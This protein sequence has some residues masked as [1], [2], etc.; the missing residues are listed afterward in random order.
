MNRRDL[1]FFILVFFLLSALMA[2]VSDP[3]GK[4]VLP[5]KQ[6]FIVL[7][8]LSDRI[9]NTDQIRRDIKV[10]ENIYEAFLLNLLAQRYFSSRD[11]F[12]IVMAYQQNAVPSA[13]MYELENELYINVGSM[14]AHMKKNLRATW[15]EYKVKVE[16]LYRLAH[17]SENSN[18]YKGADIQGYLRD[19]IIEDLP[20]DAQTINNLIILTDGYQYVEGRSKPIDEWPAVADL[21]SINVIVLEM[22]P[23]LNKEGEQRT[24]ISAW[25]DWLTRMNA[26]KIQMV[27]QSALEK[28][29]QALFEFLEV[30]NFHTKPISTKDEQI[31]QEDATSSGSDKIPDGDYISHQNGKVRSLRLKKIAEGNDSEIFECSLLQLGT[32]FQ[33][34]HGEINQESGLLTVEKLGV[35]G[36]RDNDNQI[37]LISNDKDLEYS[38]RK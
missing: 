38:L 15:P 8:D 27:V 11:E 19:R 12:K 14:P 37:S 3:P 24:M 31:I 29:R 35:F 30:G 16:E 23:N 5:P 22:S 7:L 36:I 32:G 20:K 6:N 25:S 1:F 17:F 18:D 34:L 2:C 21:S 28:E 13:K 26:R 4:R 9:L 10:I 33:K